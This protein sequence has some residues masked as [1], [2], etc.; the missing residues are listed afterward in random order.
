MSRADDF[1][2]ALTIAREELPFRDPAEI[3]RNADAEL[4]SQTKTVKIIFPFFLKPVEVTYP[5]GIIQFTEHENAL[6]LQEQGLIL[7]YLL[8]AKNVPLT[9]ELITFREIPSGEFYY[10]PFLKRAQV[11]L[12]KTFGTDYDL[13]KQ[14][15][16]K[17]GGKEFN[18]G[19][20]AMTFSPFPKTP[21]TVILWKGDEEFPPDG[22]IL[23]DTTIKLFLSSEDIALLAGTLVYRLMA[24]SRV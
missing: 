16:T 20:I 6:A 2:N 3:C 15:G 1:L 10:Q 5:E 23:F 21:V 7:H 4:I 22:T 19:D 12:V 24:L 17:L 18:M 8:G 11:P 9:G 14:S 13:F